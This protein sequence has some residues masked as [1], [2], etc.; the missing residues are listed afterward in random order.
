MPS[1][2]VTIRQIQDLADAMHPA[3]GAVLS[4]TQ[5][6]MVALT[7]RIL[8]GSRNGDS[9]GRC[10]FAVW[11][12]DG[13]GGSFSGVQVQERVNLGMAA[14]CFGATVIGK[15]PATIRPGDAITSIQAADYAEFC[16][17]TGMPA[18][19]GQLEQSQLSLGTNASI[20]VGAT[21]TL[22]PATGATVGE[23]VAAMG[24]PGSR[25]LALEGTLVRFTNPRIVA[26]VDAQGFT[27]ASIVDD[28]DATNTNHLDLIVSNFSTTSC[29]R[30]FLLAHNGM[31]VP[32][33][34]GILG[35][36]FG[37]WKLRLRD[38]LDIEG[39]NCSSPQDGGVNDGG[40]VVA[41]PLTIRALQ[42]PA[43]TMHPAKGTVVDL[44]QTGMVALTGRTLVSSRTS[45]SCR[46]AVWVS[47]GG[48]SNYSAIQVQELIP[49]G[50]AA[51]C[52]AA[53][54]GVIPTTIAPG[55]NIVR[56]TGGTYA[57]FC[58]GASGTDPTMCS[59]FE[60]SQV[61]GPRT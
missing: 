49:R 40:D 48:S 58:A 5:T 10:R 53:P 2:S 51:D 56:I 23:T 36:D 59:N 13:T 39:A 3:P 30:T 7:Q 26:S 16:T 20:V 24:A 43:D 35:P 33:M 45:T 18:D 28:S 9:S 12:G 54:S 29:V 22:Q 47:D 11:V 50:A 57:E 52:F 42:D 21:G 6:G 14:D 32:S 55:M 17:A 61:F 41:S 25:S 8:I 60:Q 46:W 37:A 44:Q 19:C 15:I 34:S 4:L 38:D 27:Q 31:T 1:T